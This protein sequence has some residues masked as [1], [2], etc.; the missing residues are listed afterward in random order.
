MTTEEKKEI[1]ESYIALKKQIARINREIEE[2][3]TAKMFPGMASGD[4]MPHAMY[5]NKDLSD[6]IVKLDS[7]YVKIIK[8]GRKKATLLV[9]IT[10]AID[11]LPDENQKDVIYCRYIQGMKWEEIC[12]FIGY[13]WKQTHRI[14]SAALKNIELRKMT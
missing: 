9:K 2:I 10:D 11:K 7:M 3:R 13:S 1:L 5:N 6:Y 4:G 14:H 12:T 8:L